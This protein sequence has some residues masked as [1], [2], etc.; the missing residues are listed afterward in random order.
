MDIEKL[1]QQ[2]NEDIIVY[3]LSTSSV[4]ISISN[5]LNEMIKSVVNKIKAI[6]L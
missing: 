5:T 3:L 6:I 2:I 4:F 1:I